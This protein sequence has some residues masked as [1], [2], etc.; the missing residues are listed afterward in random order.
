MAKS[1][2][3]S[4][5]FQRNASVRSLEHTVAK[6]QEFDRTYIW[7]VLRVEHVEG[8]FV[9]KLSGILSC[10]N[11]DGEKRRVW[12]PHLLMC[13]IEENA[14]RTCYFKN[15]GTVHLDNGNQRHAFDVDFV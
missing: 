12:A 3:D 14:E 1:F 13:E 4:E 8:K 5:T 9:G 10:E 15:L 6:W 7:K 2:I 11:Q